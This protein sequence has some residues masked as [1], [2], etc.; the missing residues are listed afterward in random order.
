[1]KVIELPP[2]DSSAVAF[3]PNVRMRAREAGGLGRMDEDES[4]M[5]EADDAQLQLRKKARR[6]LVGA[7]VFFAFAA[8]VLP[9]V[10]NQEPAPETREMEIR[11]PGQ[12]ERPAPRIVPA[13]QESDFPA[14]L[15]QEA[16]T[17]GSA[18]AGNPASP[19]ASQSPPQSPSSPPAA[20]T[21]AT[22][23]P[24]A[25]IVERLPGSGAET[26]A[27]AQNTT[28][29]TTLGTG[30]SPSAESE[31]R[32]AAAIL[33]GRVPEAEGRTPAPS[34]PSAPLAA[35]D[36]PHIILIG[37]F[38]NEANVK[39]LKTRLGELGIPAY[40]EPLPTPEGAKTRV[41][42]GPFANRVAAERALEKMKRI[43]VDGVIAIRQ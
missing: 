5:I 22:Q 12:N 2:S 21:Q 38:A 25:R 9:L 29:S 33:A 30:A 35:F 10:M 16:Q 17:T 3:V 40:T 7:I 18:G 8:L 19:P 26:Q 41:R 1:M 27:S 37:A 39:N 36:A 14:P 11:I 34:T 42:A 32:R 31:A 28:T 4:R 13:P 6:R 23:P 15:P 20:T 24:V 43:G